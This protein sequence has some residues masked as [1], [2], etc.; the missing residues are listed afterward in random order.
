MSSS[1]AST[2][3]RLATRGSALA[4]WQ[5]HRVSSLL[6]EKAPGVSVELVVISTTGD[7]R[8]DRPLREFGDKGLFVKEIEEAL[9][10]GRA[11]AAVHSLKDVPGELAPGL[12]LVATPERAD[13][14]D[15][16]VSRYPGGL[17]ALPPGARV[18]SSSLRRCGQ[19]TRLRPDLQCAD[20]RGNVD[21]RIRKVREGEY[22]AILLA[23]AGLRRLG[24]EKEISEEFSLSRMIPAPSQGILAVEAPVETPFARIWD[25]IDDPVVRVAAQAEREFVR[26]IGADCHTPAACHCTPRVD[27][28]D[29]LR[30]LAMVCL[31]DGSRYMDIDVTCSAC[32]AVETA[33]SAGEALLA[34]GAAD[35]VAAA[36]T[37]PPPPDHP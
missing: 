28:G 25:A 16:L 36:R 12:A 37:W 24:L 20:I 21:T 8:Q 27:A 3:L 32:D 2:H 31:P 13:P 4:L 15:V 22:D 26:T 6:Q 9:L 17:D 14:R 35:L 33:R 18:G 23:A 5:A 10:D 19:L 34:R 30:L 1:P 11:D 29:R 7:R